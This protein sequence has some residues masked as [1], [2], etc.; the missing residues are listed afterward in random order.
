MI[1]WKIYHG[2]TQNAARRSFYVDVNLLV[3]KIKIIIQHEN[4]HNMF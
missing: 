3:V 4:N 1:S 2:I